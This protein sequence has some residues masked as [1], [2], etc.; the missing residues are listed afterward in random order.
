MTQE[1]IDQIVEN[2]NSILSQVRNP[3]RVIEDICDP[4]YYKGR[5]KYPITAIVYTAFNVEEQNIPGF[6]IQKV[7][8]SSN[9]LYLP[10]LF[11]DQMIIEVFSDGSNPCTISQVKTKLSLYGERLHLLIFS[12]DRDNYTLSK[13]QLLYL[14]G[15][16]DIGN[17]KVV[18][19]E[20]LYEA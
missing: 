8:Y 2:I 18:R 13:L 12:V 4:D 17:A 16:T 9:R 11:N 6:E 15:F 1:Q 5:N 7:L 19:R 3:I 14:N 20:T 10:E